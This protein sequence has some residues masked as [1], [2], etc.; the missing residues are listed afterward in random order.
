[1]IICC[2]E[3]LMDLIQV[4]SEAGDP[5][6]VPLVGGAV[7]NT[8]ISL[9]RLGV[10]VAMVSGISTD[11]F[12]RQLAS[13]LDASGVNNRYLIRSGRPTTL[14]F[15]HLRDGQ[16]SYTFY[17]ENTAG[18]RIE[19]MDLPALDQAV[20][21]LFFGGIS[22]ISE[23][24]A[25]TCLALAERTAG[26]R[27][28][29]LDPNIRADFIVDEAR[30][31]ARLGRMLA[32][33]DMVKVSDDDLD[34]LVPGD[35]ELE[36]VKKLRGDTDALVIVTK[37]SAGVTAYLKD[38]E[39]LHQG[40]VRVEVVDTVGA[41]DTF[42]GGLLARLDQ[43]SLLSKQEIHKAH[44][45]QIQQALAYGARV[46]ALTISRQGANPPWVDEL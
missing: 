21:T 24:V 20:T 1:M 29:M 40:A 7:F 37:G 39:S 42:N 19:V 16:A 4:R 38:G 28:I 6:Y 14:A 41:G 46:A 17:D 45:S 35:N 36:Q 8:A 27:V 3:A 9:G 13:A 25:D 26:N 10:D 11:R 2:G 34:W 43:L 44:A 22:L 18:R 23:P 15:V 33:A 30:Y 12:G 31:R 5:C 32:V